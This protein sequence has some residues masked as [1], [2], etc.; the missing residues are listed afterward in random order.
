MNEDITTEP[1]S[2][3]EPRASPWAQTPVMD[4]GP[5]VRTQADR[6]PRQAR[7]SPE[8]IEEI[9]RETLNTRDPPPQL[10]WTFMCHEDTIEVVEDKEA[11]EQVKELKA[12]LASVSGQI[13]VS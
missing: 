11:S 13:E 7:E 3:P 2:R 4:L 8:V 9:E 5:C 1:T 12:A 10:L 6:A